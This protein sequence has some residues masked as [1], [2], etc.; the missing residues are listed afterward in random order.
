MIN[1]EMERCPM[2]GGVLKIT[3]PEKV[4]INGV[5]AYK[6]KCFCDCGYKFE[7]FAETT[8]ECFKLMFE[9]QSKHTASGHVYGLRDYSHYCPQTFCHITNHM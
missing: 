3:D 8:E 2:C 4:Y 5:L 6:G 9:A 1:T 7:A